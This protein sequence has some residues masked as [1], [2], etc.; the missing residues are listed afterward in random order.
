M[1]YLLRVNQIIIRSGSKCQIKEAFKK[2]AQWLKIN[3]YANLIKLLNKIISSNQFINQHRLSPEAFTRN[4]SLPF[5]T[6]I[7]F[8]INLIKSSI[9]NELDKFFKTV[10]NSELPQR[11]VTSSAFSQARKKLSHKAFIELN[12][13]QV[14]YFYENIDYKKWEGFRLL[15]IDGSTLMLPKNE[16]TIKEYGEFNSREETAS[17]VIA[18]VSQ[19]YDVLNKIT[20]ESIISPQSSG[21]LDLAV[22]HIK[23][24]S[25][26]VPLQKTKDIYLLDRGYNAYWIY[27]MILSRNADFCVRVNSSSWNIV[28]EFIACGLREKVCEISPCHKSKGKS[29]ELGLSV[30]PIKVRLICIDLNNGDKEILMTSLI[31]CE[32]YPYELFEDLYHN[33]WPVEESYKIMKSRI[34]IENFTGKSPEAVK[35][36]FHAR[37]FTVN[38]TSILSFSVQKKI[39]KK[40]NKYIYQI[41]WTQAI[42]KMKDSVVLLFIRKDIQL[43]IN[44][45]HYHFLKNIEPVRP[46]RIFPRMHKPK[47]HY[48]FAYKPLS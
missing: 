13:A 28:K 9:Q 18:R 38:L 29:K 32:K 4:R 33:R 30:E 25:G 2:L 44:G 34:E 31:D 20:L 21:E 15:A 41:N 5:K 26:S 19:S 46:N 3:L 8:L 10:T 17:V 22:E 45:L 24:T 27:A 12:Q 11:V 47:K 6:V 37:I 40:N 43:I 36:D 7:L 1:L 48:Y 42:A 16:Q 23:S 14:K 35:Q 39:E